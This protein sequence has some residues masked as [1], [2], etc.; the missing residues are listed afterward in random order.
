MTPPYSTDLRWR[1]VWAALTLRT[2][3]EFVGRLFNVSSRTVAKYVDLFQQRV[4]RP[5]HHG[6]YPIVGF[7]RA[8]HFTATNP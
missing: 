8:A 7:L 6:P 3:P 1:I 4:P 5:R 2:S